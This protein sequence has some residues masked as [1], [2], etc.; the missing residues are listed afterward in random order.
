MRSSAKDRLLCE[1]L[2]V[3][4]TLLYC[5]VKAIGRKAK[6]PTDKPRLRAKK[7]DNSGQRKPNSIPRYFPA[8]RKRIFLH[9]EYPLHA[10]QRQFSR[11]STP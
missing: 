9:S 3:T 11:Q 1:C 5:L 7:M 2:S 8:Y 4:W 10:N 6:K